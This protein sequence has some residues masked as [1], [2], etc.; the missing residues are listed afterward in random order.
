MSR[1]TEYLERAINGLG[2]YLDANKMM[3]LFITVLLALWLMKEKQVS[4]KA[5]RTLVYGLVMTVLLV[6]P[7]T[8]IF[9][10]LYQTA[11]YD[12]EWAWS[13]V[14]VTAV[15]AYG[16]TEF[17]SQKAAGFRKIL[18]IVMAVVLMMTGGNFGRLQKLPAEQKK[19]VTDVAEIMQSLYTMGREEDCI[20]WAPREIMQQVR[21]KNGQICLIYGKDMW[22]MK[23]GAYD[24]EAYEPA[25]TE[26]YEWLEKAV[27]Y[28]EFADRIEN[29]PEALA[30]LCE[31]YELDKDTKR[32]LKTVIRAGANTVVL[33]GTLA[34]YVKTELEEI[35]SEEK[36][37]VEVVFTEE[38][39]IYLIE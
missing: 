34:E 28:T 8:A 36:K 33:P 24:Y 19:A 38:Y 12:Y 23:S 26:A 3:A 11:F 37:S 22:D 17:V 31:Q 7:V 25:L 4:E 10:M 5:N 30:K 6:C 15:I 1:M 20:L 27:V 16:M 13:L 21:R 32:T 14:P 18:L 39:T 29:P 9:I 35:V 2:R